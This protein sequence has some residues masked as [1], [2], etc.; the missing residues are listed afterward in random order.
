MSNLQLDINLQFPAKGYRQFLRKLRTFVSYCATV[1]IHKSEGMK[2]ANRQYFKR[3]NRN[4]YTDM[5]KQYKTQNAGRSHAMTVIKLAYQNEF[6]TVS[7]GGK[8]P[9]ILIKPRYKTVRRTKKLGVYHTPR[10][11]VT[12][13]AHWKESVPRSANQQ[14]Y[15]LLSRTGDFVMYKKPNETIG[16]PPR[17]FLS[18]VVDNPPASLANDVAFIMKRALESGGSIP[19]AYNKIA[20]LVTEIA[21]SN[22]DKSP[23][24][25]HP[26]T[27]KAKG[28][29]KAYYDTQNRIYNAIKYKVYKNADKEGS[30]GNRA[31]QQ[32]MVSY[33]D[34]LLSKAQQYENLGRSGWYHTETTFRYKNFNPNYRGNYF[35]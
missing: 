5:Y 28:F 17:P 18:K 24:S 32:Q 35:I 11:R 34:K 25:N 23:I 15:L 19:K 7:Y 4:S 14:G 6:G 27:V 20:N 30:S 26:L 29:D 2:K 12:R 33:I 31:L 13:T 16:I 8:Y 9:D 10:T 22:I 21:K 3:V 1:G